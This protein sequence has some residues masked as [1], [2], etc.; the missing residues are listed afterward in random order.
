MTISYSLAPNPKWYIADL[1]GR[2]LGGGYL[3]TFRSLNKTQIKLVY[4]DPAGNFPWPY[5]TI[6]NVGSEGILF[7]EN[8][9]QGPF[10][11][12]FDTDNPSETYYL[13]VYDANGVLQ[14]TID[15][16]TPPSGGGGSVITTAIDL[17]NLVVNNTMYRN[18]GSTANPIAADFTFLA[19]GAHQGLAVTPANGGPDICFIKNNTNAVDQL[20]FTPFTLGSTPLTGDVTPTQFLKYTC[21]NTPTGETQK[22][23]QFPI[24]QNVQNL[25]N[26]SVTITLWAR[27]NSGTTTLLVQLRQFFGDGVGASPDVLFPVQTLNLTSGWAKYQMQTTV[28]NVSGKVL[29]GCRNDGLYLQIQYP[30]GASCDIDFCKPC[31]YLGN[32]SPDED[33]HTNDMVCAVIDSPRTADVKSSYNYTGN[34]YVP[35]GWIFMNDGTIGNPLSNATSRASFD[36]FPLYN[37]IWNGTSDT[38]CPVINSSGVQVGRGSSA[39]ADF[40]AN[41]SI[42]IP[43]ALGRVLSGAAP[44]GVNFSKVITRSGSTL[45]LN[46]TSPFYTGTLVEFGNSGGSLPSPL[47]INTPY[48]L[49]VTGST[50]VAVATTLAN[51]EAGIS[52]A[53]TSA[54]SGV[55]F[56][57]GILSAHP[58]ASYVGEDQHAPVISEMATHNHGITIS[59]F[60]DLVGSIG[61]SNSIAVNQGQ[62]QLSSLSNIS[63][64]ISNNGSGNKF[65]ILQPTVYAN[66]LI[67]L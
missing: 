31:M 45:I 49:I 44:T 16:F 34:N 37:L 32:I 64:T 57:T 5:V 42:S 20:T 65:N 29:G 2:P 60:R 55:S 41:N 62:S 8:G 61:S 52:I 59:Q 18:I 21:T 9:A 35:G 22:V 28:P 40:T 46:D 36:T 27:G 53:L 10:Y 12:E 26:Q 15:N 30:L 3:A 47:V 7:D 58:L 17:E 56:M 33:Y 13:E 25:T 43:K 48:Y 24:T 63:A 54:G 38:F 39:I 6:P 50:T 11:F 51:A 66:Y 67:K 23:V 1:V 4:E 14:W 19:P